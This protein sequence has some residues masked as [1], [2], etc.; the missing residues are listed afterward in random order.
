M[1]VIPARRLDIVRICV[2]KALRSD[3]SSHFLPGIIITR[4]LYYRL[5]RINDIKCN[6]DNA[7]NY[8]LIS[9]EIAIYVKIEIISKIIA[10]SNFRELFKVRVQGVSKLH[11]IT[12]FFILKIQ[13]VML[14]RFPLMKNLMILSTILRVYISLHTFLFIFLLFL[15]FFLST[16]NIYLLSEWIKKKDKFFHKFS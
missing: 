13:I 8:V 4:F 5:A 14:N 3:Q 7:S 6:E 11:S 12:Y 15:F 10:K 9:K 16:W 2:I 1:K